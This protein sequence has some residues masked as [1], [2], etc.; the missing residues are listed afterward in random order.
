MDLEQL[1]AKLAELLTLP[2]EVEWVEFKQAESN[3]H[4]ERLGKYFSAL[5][6]EANLK[7]QKCG[8]LVLGVRDTPRA[9]VGTDYRPE[10]PALDSLKQQVAVHTTNHLTFDEIYE[11]MTAE[12]R[13]VMFRIPRA[14]PGVPTAW[15]GFPYG[16]DGESLG[17]LNPH[18]QDQIRDQR[19]IDDWSARVCEQAR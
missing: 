12:G 3:L 4:F 6:N 1:E 10:R 13:V 16:R 15:K 18:E 19:R 8:W 17:P 11:L 5:S 7:N 9:I 14:L 2:A